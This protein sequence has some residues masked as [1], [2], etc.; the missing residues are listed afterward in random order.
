MNIAQRLAPLTLIAATLA[1]CFLVQSA[2][3]ATP[4]VQLE[5]VHITAQRVLAGPATVVQLPRVEVTAARVQPQPAQVVRL[6][7]VEISARRAS[8]S[9][10]LLAQRRQGATPTRNVDPA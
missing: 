10:N 8:D 7:V 9:A 5:P 3:A 1:A 4:V 6:P 2:V